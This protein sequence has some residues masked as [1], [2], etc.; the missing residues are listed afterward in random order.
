[1]TTGNGF[2]Y[3][4]ISST[5]GA[6]SHYYSHPYRFERRDPKEPLGEGL[7]APDLVKDMDWQ[8]SSAST[9]PIRAAYVD[10]S[11][12]VSVE[13]GGGRA[14]YFMPFG[15]GR[16]VLV[17]ARR[18]ARASATEPSACLRLGWTHPVRSVET[19]S[20]DG[21]RARVF[22]FERTR[23]AVVLVPLSGAADR[24]ESA[25][26]CLSGPGW[27]L[28][29]VPPGEDAVAAARDVLRWRSGRSP[30]KL[31]ADELAEFEAWRVEPAARFDSEDERHLWR[32][33]EAILRMAQSR[34]PN[35]PG[36][37]SRGWIVASIPGGDWFSVWARDMAYATSA[38]IHMGHRDEARRALEAYFSARPVG[39]MSAEVGGV[40][41]Q[42]SA[43]RYFGDGAEE[44]YFTMEGSKNVEF[45][46]WGL[47]LWVLG[48]YVDRFG[49][50]AFLD[51]PTYRGAIYDS[52]KKYVA[53]PL[54][55]NLERR[56]AG[57][58]VAKDTSIWEERQKD[59]K[60]FAFSTIAAIRGLRAM[61]ALAR[62]RGDEPFHRELAAAL[63]RLE[64]GFRDAFVRDSAV[65]GAL[66]DGI[67]NEV[68]GAALS[69]FHFEVIAD[70]AVMRGTVARMPAL[71]VASGG[72]RRVRCILTDP[73][74]FEYYYERQEFLFIDFSLAETYLRL[75]EPDKAAALVDRMTARAERD[76]GFI[77]EMYVSV[78]N[79]L[80]VGAIGDPTG[81]IP[82]VGYGAGVYIDYL[83]TRER[84]RRRP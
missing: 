79:P 41:Y 30:E 69:A 17:A 43:V 83:L 71:A 6:V 75:G 55:K 28:A 57:L 82:M 39:A 77:P 8:E 44:P 11:H 9:G 51:E 3:A 27:A 19:L 36:R 34:E 33:S 45:D 32:Q 2:G 18:P 35:R 1:L 54:L 81:S 42:V 14:V 60:H 29:T 37:L 74:I 72:F 78:E 66:E 73:K 76:H 59:A 20:V 56:G 15:L 61:D 80:F 63:A 22:R 52:A 46:N 40:P 58:I 49:D 65:R 62:R 84:L 4:V 24:P 67:K 50:A 12:V 23:E 38:L 26:G 68:D 48:E 64:R 16:N 70:T 10:D 25:P 31:E 7:E 21:T 53:R 13:A 47:V 5:S